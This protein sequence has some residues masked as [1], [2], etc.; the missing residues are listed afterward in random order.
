MSTVQDYINQHSLKES[1]EEAINA[2]VRDKSEDPLLFLSQFFAAKSASGDAAVGAILKVVGRMIIDSRGNPT[3]EADVYT[4]KG[5]FRA[6]VPSGAST[7]IYEAVELRDGG[8][9]WMGKGVTKAVE[10]INSKIGPAL[11]GKDPTEQKEIDAL[12]KTLDG[13]ENKSVIGANAILAVSLAVCKAGA[14]K[15]GV[16]LYKHIADLAG[17]T[18][19]VLPVPSFNIINGGS[20]AGNALAMQEFMILPV[21]AT[22]FKEAMRM[23]CEVYHNLKSLIKEKY[24]QDAC[25]VGDEGGFAPNIQSN[26]EGLNLVNAAI[27]KAGYTGKVKI[28]MD[29]AASEFLTKDKHYDLDFKNPGNDGS[30]KKTGKEMLEIYKKFCADY[31]IITIEDP[32]D[33]DDWE[34]T[35]AFTESGACQV[36]GDD[37][38]VTNPKRVEE[39]IQKKAC[40]A[41]LLKVNQI[42]TVTESI[43]A[44]R[45]SKAAGWGVMAS[46]RSGETEDSFIADLSVGLATGQIKTGAPCRSERLAKYNQLLRIEEELGTDAVYAGENWR[47]LAWD[48]PSTDPAKSETKPEAKPETKPKADS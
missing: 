34:N 35:A 22:S 37:L 41:L 8:K 15:K 48:V 1:V 14:A 9:E 36:V 28:G 40:N 3:C 39:A 33:Q 43:E 29:V 31:P 25:N 46:H 47:H 18:K 4:N 32:F 12:M 6:A 17:N 7:G 45:M 21:G 23:G 26:D 19:L 16:P 5:M 10:N 44:V 27:E 13:T 2:C 30:Q 11:V 42:G 20:H 24:G 38:L